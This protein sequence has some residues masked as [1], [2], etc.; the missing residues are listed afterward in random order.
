MIVIEEVGKWN[1]WNKIL[2]V[3]CVISKISILM[4]VLI[5]L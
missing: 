1:Y 5:D 4:F 2:I 3:C